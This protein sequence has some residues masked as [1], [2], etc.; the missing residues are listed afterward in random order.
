MPKTAPASGGP[1]KKRR[2]KAAP[3]RTSGSQRRGSNVLLTT[4]V[5]VTLAVAGLWALGTQQKPP[6]SVPA[7][8]R[9]P[10]VPQTADRTA[11]AAPATGDP[12]EKPA[13]TPSQDMEQPKPVKSGTTER[14]PGTPLPSGVTEWWYTPNPNHRRPEMQPQTESLLSKHNAFWIGPNAKTVYLTFDSGYD[15]GLIPEFL[16]VLKKH[17]AKA[18]FFYTGSNLQQH[19]DLVKTTLAAGH[20][21]GNHT[22]T[23]QWPRSSPEKLN[24]EVDE[25]QRIYGNITGGQTLRYFR[26]PE[27]AYNEAVLAQMQAKGYRTAFWSLALRDWE[28]LAGGKQAAYH[29]VVDHLHPGAVILLHSISKDDLDAMDD[30]L[31]AAEKQGYSFGDPETL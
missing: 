11:P 13:Q 25:V 31:T 7:S 23:H 9:A 3:R 12:K 27:G 2:T 15:K 20:A 21:I 19:P 1:A 29:A 16:K 14:D 30:I 5:V 17:G 10:A 6:E 28:P 18:M 4:A 8:A 26:F 22:V 24:Q